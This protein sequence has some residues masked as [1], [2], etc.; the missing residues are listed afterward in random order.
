MRWPCVAVRGR[1]W[2]C[3]NQAGAEG[4]LQGRRN[5][6][7]LGEGTLQDVARAAC[8]MTRCCTLVQLYRVRE[9]VETL[10]SP[11]R[12]KNYVHTATAI[13]SPPPNVPFRLSPPLQ[14]PEALWSSSLLIP[15]PPHPSKA[16]PTP[17]PNPDHESRHLSSQLL[18][19]PQSTRR[20]SCRCSWRI[21]HERSSTFCL[22]CT[23]ASMRRG[24]KIWWVRG[25]W[26][27]KCPRR[28]SAS[29]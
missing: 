24:S 9:T 12:S 16:K 28:S 26:S 6:T 4:R 14:A 13:T 3:V 27:Y 8:G 2:Q 18:Q 1:A 29:W 11:A 10:C 5:P 7:R 15:P 17:R 20:S 22:S 21:F 25:N 23:V 19:D